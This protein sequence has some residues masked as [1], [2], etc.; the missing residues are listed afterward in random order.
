[1]ILEGIHTYI[2]PLYLNRPRDM[3]GHK[4]RVAR[5]TVAHSVIGGSL[6]VRR[7]QVAWQGRS[8]VGGPYSTIGSPS[9]EPR[10]SGR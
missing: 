6:D 2:A 7:Q 3:D 8:L 10:F 1:M 5:G 9:S 4:R